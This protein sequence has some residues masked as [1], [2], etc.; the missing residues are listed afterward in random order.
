MLVN[1]SRCIGHVSAPLTAI[2]S[3]QKDSA[4]YWRKPYSELNK[5]WNKKKKPERKS[6][7]ETYRDGVNG[8]PVQWILQTVADYPVVTKVKVI[9]GDDHDSAAR[10]WVLLKVNIVLQLKVKQHFYILL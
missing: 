9:C 2:V 3:G 5:T 10:W 1:I 8:K 4:S 7:S 6:R